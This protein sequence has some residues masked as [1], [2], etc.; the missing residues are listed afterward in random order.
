MAALVNEMALWSGSTWLILDDLHD[1][2]PSD[3]GGLVTFV[4][5]LP[6]TTHVVLRDPCR[7]RCCRSTGGG[8]GGNWLRSGMLTSAWK[9]STS[10]PSCTSTASIFPAATYILWPQ[11]PRDGWPESSWQPFRCCTTPTT[12]PRSSDALMERSRWLPISSSKRCSTSSPQ[13][14][15][16]S[17]TQPRSSTS[18][19]WN[20][21]TLF[22]VT[23]TALT[24]LRRAMNSG[25]F[26]VAL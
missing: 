4:E 13:K 22:S 7:S 3:L 17:C 9:K 11:G 25:L 14:W 15:C 24:S 26:V 23:S 1:V 16:N 19:T 8:P 5:R 10:T 20:W 6:A 12:R 18:S 2:A 21:R